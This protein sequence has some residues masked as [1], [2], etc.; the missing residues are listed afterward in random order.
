MFTKALEDAIALIASQP[1][2]GA[3]AVSVRLRGVRRVYL[4]AT[5]H[6]LYYRVH[7]HP[8]KSIEVVAVWHS[9]RGWPPRW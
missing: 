8:P 9:S 6:Y 5:G 3:V 2:I 4:G 1:Y 7:G